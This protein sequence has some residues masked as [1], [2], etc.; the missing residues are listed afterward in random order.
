MWFAVTGTDNVAAIDTTSLDPSNF[1][2]AGKIIP[3]SYVPQS[4]AVTPDGSQVW[5]VDSG[6]QTPTTPLWGVDVIATSTNKVVRHVN[7]V[8][9]PT[10]VAFSPN[11]QDAYVTTSNGLYVYGTR[12]TKQVAF[13]AGLGSPKSVAVAPDGADVYVTETDNAKPATISATTDKVVRTTSVGQEPWEA[14]VT[15]DGATVYVANPN[16]DSISV[17]DATTLHVENTLSVSGAA[18]HPGGDPQRV[19]AVGGRSGQRHPHGHQ[20]RDGRH[21]GPD[22]PGWVRAQFR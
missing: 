5:V 8:G 2:L 11:G 14:A 18:R 15:P 16:S 3:V 6:P 17:I 1:N 21:G 12:N 7:L 22:Q 10:D 9:D 20:H 19:S 4:V 13:V